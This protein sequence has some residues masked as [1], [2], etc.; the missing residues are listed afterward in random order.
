MT[1]ANCV[2][3]TNGWTDE[4]ASEQEARHEA[5]KAVTEWQ[6]N[7][8]AARTE[9]EQ[10]LSKL[11][12]ANGETE[13]LFRE[14]ELAHAHG[15]QRAAVLL[16]EIE[17]ARADG[18]QQVAALNEQMAAARQAAQ[19]HI[20]TLTA[21][22]ETA[23]ADG[24]QQITALNEQMAAARTASQAH[25]DTLA[26]EIE[27]ARADGR[28][29]VAALNEQLAAA[30]AAARA[31]IDTLTAEIE[32]ARADGRQQVAAL[33]EQLAT[34]LAA[35]QAHA[36]KLNAEIVTARAHSDQRASALMVEIENLRRHIGELGDLQ[37]EIGGLRIT[38]E[39]VSHE[40]GNARDEANGLREQFEQTQNLLLDNEAELR[41]LREEKVRWE[42]DREFLRQEIAGLHSELQAQDETL[43]QTSR[44]Q[45]DT[46][47]ALAE[48][49][50]RGD[51]DHGR[52]RSM[53]QSASWKLTLPLRMVSRALTGKR[54]GNGRNGTH[55]AGAE[56]PMLSAEAMAERN[57]GYR[58]QL[59][60]PTDWNLPMQ[61]ARVRGW[62]LPPAGKGI[63]KL[64]LCCGDRTT[65]VPCDVARPDVQAAH[66]LGPEYNLCGFGPKDRL[67]RRTVA[68]VGGS[69]GRAGPGMARRPVQGARALCRVDPAR[70][71]RRQSGHGLFRLDRL[72]R[73]AER[74]RPPPHPRAGP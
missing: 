32:T 46:H 42:Q 69:R 48:A 13:T 71:R 50:L 23:R 73:R 10:A 8:R 29:Q 66:G 21:E 16:G 44:Q 51:Q 65:E 28:Q 27:M 43:V 41:E 25:I 1:C 2:L 57:G 52:V 62:C 53:Q 47:A 34:A 22:I 19:A 33:S 74:R 59:D 18:R 58:F 4:L 60:L 39:R 26:A 45:A 67:A 14:V 37:G 70:S 20:D 24:R 3:P 56:T 6:L 30:Q 17:L 31:H 36:E 12:A 61:Q 63:P 40:L 15:D 5:A 72:L 55:P 9:L 35:G 54:P 49:R 7:E 64:R 11:H 68:V 38:H